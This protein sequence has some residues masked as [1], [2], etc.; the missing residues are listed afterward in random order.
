MWSWHLQEDSR[1]ALPSGGSA[2]HLPR[3]RVEK[4]VMLPRRSSFPA[5]SVCRTPLESS[6]EMGPW[7][8]PCPSP[9]PAPE[10]PALLP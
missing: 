6:R 3:S 10:V 1:N 2:V 5:P 9:P 8:L 7:P 4:E